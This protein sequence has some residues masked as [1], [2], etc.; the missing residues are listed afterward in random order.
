MKIL[1]L[2]YV[3]NDEMGSKLN[4]YSIAGNKMQKNII[5]NMSIYFERTTSISIIPGSSYP[6]N[7]FLFY[8]GGKI[9]I[10]NFVSYSTPFI[11]IPIIKQIMQIIGTIKLCKKH[12]DKNTVVFSFNSFPLTGIPSIYCKRKFKCL[13]CSYI[14][15]LP[16]SDIYI[17]G[18]KSIAK[19]RYEELSNYLITKNDKLVF[20]NK[21]AAKMFHKNKFLIIEGGVDKKEVLPIKKRKKCEN[22]ILLYTGALTHY[23]G[24]KIL[25]EAMKLVN[26]KDIKLEIYGNGLLR[27][28][29]V[30]EVKE[31]N[32]VVYCGCIN[33]NEI[34][35]K[36]KEAY[37]LVNPRKAN[38]LISKTTFPSKIFEYLVSG[39]PTLMTRIEGIP[40]IYYRYI[41]N[42]KDDAKSI[43]NA[44]NKIDMIDWKEKSNKAKE[45]YDYIIN[46]KTWDKQCKK[47]Y[48][49][50]IKN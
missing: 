22:K 47:I 3:V 44:I 1:F 29:I 27:E 19:K 4:G 10:D 15:D 18:I 37:L 7:K 23:S 45:A 14:A 12:V 43:A 35:L 38:N 31:M 48:N 20:I 50:L 5:K 28:E 24:V 34:L 33:N 42:C 17:G 40:K 8:K 9:D 49:F 2:T 16:I 36:Q 32:N 11:N 6:K 25:I 13:T 39:T 26:N 30:K 41:Y 21:N 46:N